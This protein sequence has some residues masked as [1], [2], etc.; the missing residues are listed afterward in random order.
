M[1][2]L[3]ENLSD[4]HLQALPIL[5]GLQDGPPEGIG[6]GGAAMIAPTPV[7]FEQDQGEDP[8]LQEPGALLLLDPGEEGTAQNGSHADHHRQAVGPQVH[9]RLLPTIS[10]HSFRYEW[11]GVVLAMTSVCNHLSEVMMITAKS[12]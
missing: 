9:L 2:V 7:G 1:Q 5:R 10:H 11:E 4:V 3:F 8:T 12:L 6:V